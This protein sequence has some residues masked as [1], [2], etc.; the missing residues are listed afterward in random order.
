MLRGT[1]GHV[2][3]DESDRL[4]TRRSAH[5][6]PAPAAQPGAGRAHRAAAEPV[7]VAGRHGPSPGSPGRSGRRAHPARRRAAGVPGRLLSRMCGP[8]RRCAHACWPRKAD[9]AKHS[10]GPG[11]RACPRTTTSRTCR[12]F[13]H[14]TLAKV[15][16]ARYA[17]DGDKSSLNDASRLLERLQ[18]AAVAGGRTGSVI[19][20]LVLQSL[21]HQAGGDTPRRAGGAGRGADPGGTGRLRSGIRR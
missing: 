10:T 13:E 17:T 5:R 7:P 4:R 19:E 14:I 9:G 18:S 1:R 16:L 8:S 20:I 6:H 21:T 11:S 12:E 15:L 2:R 3:R